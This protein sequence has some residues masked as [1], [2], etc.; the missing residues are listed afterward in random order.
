MW[1]PA[2]TATPT[3]GWRIFAQINYQASEY[4]S[5]DCSRLVGAGQLYP[6]NYISPYTAS[7]VKTLQDALTIPKGQESY[8]D[9]DANDLGV[10]NAGYG[11]QVPGVPVPKLPRFTALAKA[12]NQYKTL[13]NPAQLEKPVRSV[14]RSE[15]EMQEGEKRR[16]T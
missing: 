15:H 4:N 6:L 1:H 13:S 8:N 10:V 16:K 9:S 12:I 3:A 11:F 2:D 5:E 7:P 14:S